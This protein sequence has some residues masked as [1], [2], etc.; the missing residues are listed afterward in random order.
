LGKA[1]KKIKKNKLKA[2]EKDLNEKINMFNRLPD[3]CL[4]CDAKFDKNNKEMVQD[5]YVVVRNETKTVKLYCPEC[6]NRAK[7]LIEQ[8][9]THGEL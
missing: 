5:W 6:W 3:E 4:V 8:I 2:K 9:K 1:T 7:D